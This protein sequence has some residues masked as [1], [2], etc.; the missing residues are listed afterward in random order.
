MPWTIILVTIAVILIGGSIV[1][2]L[3][4]KLAAQ[5]MRYEDEVERDE[6]KARERAAR[7]RSRTVVIQ[8]PAVPP[9][10]DDPHAPASPDKDA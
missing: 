7:E 3:W 1:A 9:A 2:W 8:R 6:A 5:A 10:E 4:W